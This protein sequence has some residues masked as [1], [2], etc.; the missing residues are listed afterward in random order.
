MKRFFLFSGDVLI[1]YLSLYL[2]LFLRYGLDFNSQISIHLMPFSL[3]F[4]FW[5]IV[6]YI[7]GLYE[8]NL[9]KNLPEFYSSL[10]KS[11]AISTSISIIFFYLIPL[12]IIQIA[13]RRNL[14]IYLAVFTGLISL[15]RYLYNRL[16]EKTFKNNTIIVGFDQIS[17]EFAK[18]LN[19]NP[20]YG[21]N[22]RYAFDISEQAAFSFRDIDFRQLRGTR[23]MERILND[24]HINTIILSPEA[25]RLPNIIDF[26]YKASKKGIQFVNLATAYERILK[27]VPLEAI[28]QLWFL[29]KVSRA[30]KRFYEFVK[31]LIDIVLSLIG[32]AGLIVIFP[33]VGSAIKLTSSGPLFYKQGRVGKGGKIFEVVKF[34][35]MIENAEMN[36]A[37]WAT[38]EDPRVTKFGK[39]LRKTR[40]DELPQVFNILKGEMSIVGPRAERPE[41]VEKLKKEIPFYEERLLVRPGLSGWAQINYGKD[42]DSNDTKEKLQYDL[43]YIKNRSLTIDLAII[44][45]TIK[46]ILSATGW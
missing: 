32:L 24:E 36:G 18:F 42:L 43:Y 1:L 34:R 25:Y 39:F 2:T 12:E 22:L 11:I 30:E 14:L 40:L 9:S 29:E 46:T 35:T 27:K 21:Y 15:W 19:R 33:F 38:K 5:V 26:F 31:R 16:L 7:A 41:F 45:K 4:I 17:F 13:P 8:L 10:F 23:D 44:L 37:T 20:Q 3:L 28:S 6:F